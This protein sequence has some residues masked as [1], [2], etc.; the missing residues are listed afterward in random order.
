ML[1]VDLPSSSHHTDNGK[2]KK[3][4]GWLLLPTCYEKCLGLLTHTNTSAAQ[5]NHNPL[6]HLWPC[7]ISYLRLYQVNILA[8]G[9]LCEKKETLNVNGDR[10][11]RDFV[12][13]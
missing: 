7:I 8:V 4:K 6:Q 13:L 11:K 1:I 12:L 5:Q 2:V 10:V 3:K 9:L